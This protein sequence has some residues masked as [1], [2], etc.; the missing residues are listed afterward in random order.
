MA[1]QNKKTREE[2]IK[3]KG[4]KGQEQLDLKTK[5]SLTVSFLLCTPEILTY[6]HL[7]YLKITLIHL[8]YES[9]LT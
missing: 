1:P 9:L 6:N 5:L 4:I 3:E 2:Q 7:H 8:Q